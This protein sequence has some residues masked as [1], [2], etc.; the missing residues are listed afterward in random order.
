MFGGKS[1]IF[2]KLYLRLFDKSSGERS[3]FRFRK[4][5]LFYFG[6]GDSNEFS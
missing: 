2:A 3:T 1:F 4:T 5:F 6:S